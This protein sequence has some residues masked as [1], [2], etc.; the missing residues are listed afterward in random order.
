MDNQK[1]SEVNTTIEDDDIIKD[2]VIESAEELKF[3]TNSR[4]LFGV[5]QYK[6]HGR[7]YCF[8]FDSQN[9]PRIVI[10]PHCKRNSHI[11]RSMLYWTLL[12]YF[13]CRDICLFV[14]LGYVFLWDQTILRSF[15]V[16]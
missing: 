10:G 6:K 15:I 2:E 3:F 8:L 1:Y 16:F 5:I 9:K 14:V 13:N 7:M 4:S 11:N 12:Y